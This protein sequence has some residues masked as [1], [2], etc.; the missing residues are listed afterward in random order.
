MTGTTTKH[1][2]YRPYDAGFPHDTT[3]FIE[4]GKYGSIY[5]WH[6][7]YVTITGAKVDIIDS[8]SMYYSTKLSGRLTIGEG[9]EVGTINLTPGTYTPNALIQAGAKVGKVVYTGEKTMQYVKIEAGAE[10]DQLIINN[11]A[12]YKT[13]VIEDGADIDEIICNGTSYTLAQWRDFISQ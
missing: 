13:I 10:V 8:A 4:G 2:D 3:T 1:T 9:A 11:V 7:A 12:N 6:R 5:L